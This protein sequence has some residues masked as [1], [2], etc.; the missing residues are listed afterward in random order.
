MAKTAR[1]V[2]AVI[3]DEHVT[4]LHHLQRLVSHQIIAGKT[5]NR[6]RGADEVDVPTIQVSGWRR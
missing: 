4:R 6:H 1:V 3:D 5:E 2:V